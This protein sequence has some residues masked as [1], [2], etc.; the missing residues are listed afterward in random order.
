MTALWE[1]IRD[2][3]A[4]ETGESIGELQLQSV[5]GGCIN[6]AQIATADDGQSYFVKL[7]AAH[8]AGMFETEARALREMADTK[9]IRVPEP[10]C[11]G[12]EG[13]KAFLVLEAICMQ[14]RGDSRLM[15]QQLA[16]LHRVSSQ[17]RR[18]GWHED[19]VIGE[20]PQ[21]NGWKSDWQEFWL[22][23][24]LG[25]QV[26]L[27]SNKGLRLRGVEELIDQSSQLF[28]GYDPA[29]SLVHGDLWGG[30]ASFDTEGH[31]VLFDPA[32]YYGDREVDLAFTHMFGGFTNDFYR[33]YDEEW[34]LAEGFERRQRWYNLYHE[35]NH[36]NLFGGGYG[37]QAQA[38]VSWL[39]GTF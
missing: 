19:N 10:L 25:F 7:N 22:D 6:D 39:L 26:E 31:P 11:W 16:A 37:S 36:F 9:T 35:L 5:G 15:G 21:P 3:I 34:S 4:K 18:Y 24:R 2:A 23:H 20:T 27:A 13:A 32:A 38:S 28:E 29:P 30:N 12:V 8:K 1:A 14:G 17:D 33:G